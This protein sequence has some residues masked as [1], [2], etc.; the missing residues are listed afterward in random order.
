MIKFSNIRK[1]FQWWY[2]WLGQHGVFVGRLLIFNFSFREHVTY[3]NQPCRIRIS[4]RRHAS[5]LPIRWILNM[6]LMLWWCLTERGAHFRA[7]H[8]DCSRLTITWSELGRVWTKRM[9]QDAVWVWA[10][11][12]KFMCSWTFIASRHRYLMIGSV[13]AMLVEVASLIT[14]HNDQEMFS[15][16]WTKRKRHI[17]WTAKRSP[18]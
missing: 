10:M 7:L 6:G 3:W 17:E 5:L 2:D 8:T 15:T 12:A 16:G 13:T 14:I 18:Q 9:V 11:I 1:P 4:R